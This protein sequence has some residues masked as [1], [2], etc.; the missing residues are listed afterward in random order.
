ML[1]RPQE[2][3]DFRN[4]LIALMH[5]VMHAWLHSYIYLTI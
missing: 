3:M 5:V 1:V 4:Y 2:E